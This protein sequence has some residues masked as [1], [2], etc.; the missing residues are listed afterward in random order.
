[1][2][3]YRGVSTKAVGLIALIVALIVSSCG[4]EGEAKRA[5]KFQPIAVKQQAYDPASQL[6]SYPIDLEY[7][8]EIAILDL[9][10]RAGVPREDIEPRSI[11]WVQASN[12]T[13]ECFRLGS[14]M[15]A[16]DSPRTLPQSMPCV[17]QTSA[18]ASLTPASMPFR[19]QM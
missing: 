5:G 19:P 18:N 3:A 15:L 17:R 1:M 4:G 8:L 2:Y 10:A 11:H 13:A 9:G 14:N 7:P 16:I 6:N 12:Q